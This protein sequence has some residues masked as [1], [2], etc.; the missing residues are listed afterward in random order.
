M[1]V[2]IFEVKLSEL[3]SSVGAAWLEI[4]FVAPHDFIGQKLKKLQ[5]VESLPFC[6]TD[7]AFF[8]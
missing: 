7:A 3:N 1:G 5:Q 4:W 2:H 6:P 8:L